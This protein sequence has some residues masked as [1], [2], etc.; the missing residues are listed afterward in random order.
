MI[1]ATIFFLQESRR[2]CARAHETRSIFKS[3]QMALLRCQDNTFELVSLKE[4]T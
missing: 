3:K 4:V 1:A 2:Y